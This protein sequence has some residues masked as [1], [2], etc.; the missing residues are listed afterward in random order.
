M[1]EETYEAVTRT[2]GSFFAAR[3]GLQLIMRSKI[4]F[5]VNSVL[6]PENRS[7][8]IEYKSW[9]A[10]LPLTKG[11]QFALPIM[12]LHCRARRDSEA[13]NEFIKSLRISPDEALSIMA[14][15]KDAFVSALREY[16]SRSIQD[17]GDK[18]FRCG[19]GVGTACLDAY[20]N[21]QLCLLLRHQDTVYPL[22]RGSLKDAVD[23]FFQQVRELTPENPEYI[24]RC[25]RCFLRGLLCDQCPAKSWMEN[26]TLDSP[27][28][29]LCKIAH[30]KARLIGILNHGESAW[31]IK[32]G[33]RRMVRFIA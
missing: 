29:Y 3:R 26:G 8:L 9:A 22:G 6:L 21:Y 4:P 20:G 7:E 10:T 2:A 25:H 33:K 11:E 17:S 28:E 30:C 27:V 12:L 32:N 18:L 15:D 14:E 16:C 1:K 23:V 13:K 19:A 24:E 5:M 31:N